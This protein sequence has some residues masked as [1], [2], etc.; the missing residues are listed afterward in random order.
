MDTVNKQDKILRAFYEGNQ[1]NAFDRI[2][3]RRKKTNNES[4][5]KILCKYFLRKFLMIKYYETS[6]RF[7]CT[8]FQVFEIFHSKNLTI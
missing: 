4:L 6:I 2:P 1:L 5:L 8:P 7:D 3:E